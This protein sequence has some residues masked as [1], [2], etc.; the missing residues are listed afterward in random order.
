MNLIKFTNNNMKEKF[1]YD[2]KGVILFI[3]YVACA[4]ALFY[5]C[6]SCKAQK[7]EL[8]R[9]KTNLITEHLQQNEF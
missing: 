9:T 4:F 7:K 5:V 3:I 1:L 8:N 6:S 2:L